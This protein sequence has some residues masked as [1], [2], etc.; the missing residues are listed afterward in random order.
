MGIKGFWFFVIF[1]KGTDF[2]RLD[3]K[4][5]QYKRIFFLDGDFFG[6]IN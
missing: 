5:L 4:F 2:S 6:R 3:I 1:T